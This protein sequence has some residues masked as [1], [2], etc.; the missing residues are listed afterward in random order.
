MTWFTLRIYPEIPSSG[1][2][3]LLV[4]IIWNVA[5]W[6]ISFFYNK[7]A[8]YKTPKIGALILF[9]FKELLIASGRVA[10]EVVTPTDHMRPAVVAIPLEAKTDLEIT[11]LANF[12]TLTPGTLS[13]D[14]SRDR[15]T[16]YIHELYVKS[17]D[18]ER[19]RR[20]IKDGFEKKILKITR[21]HY[22]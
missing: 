2:M 13:I 4:F 16:L 6:L 18:K 7:K 14:V 12:I 10:Y 21:R 9:Y 22:Q 1:F 19:L 5:L 3:V 11:L 15:K 8:F 17:G 20:Q